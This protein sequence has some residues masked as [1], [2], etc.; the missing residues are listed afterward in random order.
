MW[1]EYN[2]HGNHAPIYFGALVPRFGAFQA[3]F[4]DRRSHD[5]MVRIR[6]IPFAW[7]G[8]LEDLPRGIDDLGLQAVAGS[9]P[10]NALSALAIEVL[11]PFQGLG[12][13]RLALEGMR[14][15]ARSGGFSRLVAPV[16]PSWKDRYP[17]VPI[18]EYVTWLRDDGLPFDP[19]IRVHIRAGGAVL[20]CEPESM[21]ITA[22]RLDWERWT[23]L[24]FSK[25]GEYEFPGGLSCLRVRGDAAEYHEPNV[26]I[27]HQL[28][29]A[30]DDS[31]ERR[32]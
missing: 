32:P 5:P 6:S 19:W 10:P 24:R 1:P 25:D 29:Q 13:S 2:H 11:P 18:D 20:R 14:L 16:R 9:K 23:K 3:L 21:E 4:V 12:L 8:T 31:D 28:D 17:L 7:D 22:S 30:K 27:V 15:M 26:W